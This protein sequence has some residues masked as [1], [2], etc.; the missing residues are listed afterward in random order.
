[1]AMIHSRPGFSPRITRESRDGARVTAQSTVTKDMQPAI[2]KHTSAAAHIPN[3]PL[4]DAAAPATISPEYMQAQAEAALKRMQAAAAAKAA[5]AP[6]IIPNLHAS[7]A[8]IM[9]SPHEE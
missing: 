9:T 6:E 2:A 5:G 4:K 7:P 1:M 8:P 3:S